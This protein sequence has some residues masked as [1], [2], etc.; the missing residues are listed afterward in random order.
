[1]AKMSAAD[2]PFEGNFVGGATIAV[3]AEA[4]NVIRASIQLKT[5]DGES[6]YERVHA[7][8]HLSDASTG[9][10]ISTTAPN[11]GVAAGTN[12][13]VLAELVA[14]KLFLC[15]SDAS[16]RIDLDI[17]ESGT[18]TFYLVV[19]IPGGRRVVSSAITFA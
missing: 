19:L 3:G 11:G 13:K 4:V 5:E 14:D 8:A 9:S 15:E 16:G 6:I 1:M 10:G 7:L 2:N 18:P 17:T 12:G